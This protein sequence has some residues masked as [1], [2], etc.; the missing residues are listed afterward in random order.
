[1]KKVALLFILM[2][3]FLATA[4]ETAN[5]F[6]YELTYKP[7]RDSAS[8]TK[9][10]MVLD[11][12]KGK[13]IYQDYTNV[14]QDSVQK[15]T[16][17]AMQKAGTFDPDFMKK[18]KQPKFSTKII[19][20]YPSM[21]TQNVE[22][23]FSMMKPMTVS[24]TEDYKFN[25]KI[26]PDKQKIGEYEGQKATTEFGGRKWTAWFST[27]LPFPDG[28]YKFSG[29]PGLIIKLEDDTKSY[30]WVLQANKKLTDYYDKTYMERTFMPNNTI[31]DLPKE[32]FTKTFNDFKKD[33]FGSMRQYMKPEM[34]SQ[35]FPGSNKTMGEYMKDSEKMMDKLYNS[36][37]NPIE[38]DTTNNINIAPAK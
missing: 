22:M 13:S 38:L 36:I 34:M 21:K 26:L 6:I 28:P 32:K 8:M 31:T 35:K 3:G 5:R 12:S 30:S 4:Q 11:I 2:F 7:K 18:M 20:A 19:K 24:Y 17:D 14:S 37:D 27:D 33:P 29:L 23:I 25:W 9:E 10:L 16:M 15:A 1:M